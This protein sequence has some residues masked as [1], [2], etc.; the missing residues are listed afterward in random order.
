MIQK[1]NAQFP[2][3]QTPAC[4]TLL[5][6]F[7]TGL[8]AQNS[9]AANTSADNSPMRVTH[10]LGFERLANNAGGALSI[11]GST[12]RFQ[13]HEGSAAQISIGAIQ[14][15]FL[16]MEDKQVG[17]VPLA[18]GRAAAPFGGGRAVALFSHKKYDTLTLEYHD[19]NGAL[20]GAIFQLNKGHGPALRD[21]LVAAG[22]HAGIERQAGQT[23]TEIK[24]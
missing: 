11:Q 6:W 23:A 14:G 24:K 18:L 16:G 9:A 1:R 15:V 3:R 8:V 2:I 13:G 20:H 19:S 4:L 21:K 5:I 22:A 10:I 7:S 17:G 12:L